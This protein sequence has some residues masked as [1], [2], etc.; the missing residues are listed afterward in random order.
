MTVKKWIV[1]LSVEE[2]EQ[3]RGVIKKGRVGGR[4]LNRAHIL[5]L[6]DEGQTDDVIAA[7]LHTGLSTVERTRR[8]CVEGGVEHALR[9][10]TRPKRGTKLDAKGRAMLVATACSAPP[11]GRVTWTMQLLADRLVELKVV[12]A[13]SDETVRTELKKMI[14]SR[15]RKNNGAFRRSPASL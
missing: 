4:K 7:A 6:A 11:D 10:K 9:E 8:K 1:N 5:L 2:R 3:L 12:D 14:S 13:I 15:G